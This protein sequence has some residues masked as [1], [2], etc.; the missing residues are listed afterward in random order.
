MHHV[1]KVT[2][3]ISNNFPLLLLLRFTT[4]EHFQDK[5]NLKKQFKKQNQ[6]KFILFH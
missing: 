3:L 1:I 6:N 4:E 5:D 2:S